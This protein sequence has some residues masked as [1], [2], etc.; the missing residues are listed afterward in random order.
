MQESFLGSSAEDLSKLEITIEGV[1]M[2]LPR[3]NEHEHST[4]TKWHSLMSSLMRQCVMRH[5]KLPWFW[6]QEGSKCD[7]I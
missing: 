2:I 6:R 5:F 1:K 3:Q 4:K 7:T